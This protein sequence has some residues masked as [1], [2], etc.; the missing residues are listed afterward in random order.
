[1][2]MLANHADFLWASSRVPSPRRREED[3][4][5]EVRIALRAKW[6]SGWEAMLIRSKKNGNHLYNAHVA[7]FSWFCTWL[8]QD[9]VVKQ[10]LCSQQ[11]FCLTG[12]CWPFWSCFSSDGLYSSS[13]GIPGELVMICIIYNSALVLGFA[14]AFTQWVYDRSRK[15]LLA[16]FSLVSQ[17]PP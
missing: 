4:L 1:M 11:L 17:P 15:T 16:L 7:F 12:T 10:L 2:L 8:W 9:G 13:F 3:C 5:M 6:T 14:L